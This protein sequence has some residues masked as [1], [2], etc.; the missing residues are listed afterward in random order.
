M[1]R[2]LRLEV[3]NFR[4]WREGTVP[5]DRQVTVVLGDNRRGKSSTLNAIEWC[6][7]GREI[8]KKA[9][10]IAERV[11]WE[12]ERR[13]SDAG[14]EVAL[15]IE[16]EGEQARIVRRRKA[17]AGAREE[18]EVAVEVGGARLEQ[19]QARAWMRA[20]RLPDWETW[21]RAC[22]QHQEVLRGRLTVAEDRSQVVASL[23][24]MDEYDRLQRVLKDQQPGKLIGEIDRELGELDKV[25][26]YRLRAP[27]EELY[28]SERKLEALGI[29]RARLSPG[30]AGEIARAAI[31][32]AGALAARLEIQARLPALEGDADEP[33]VRKW[34]DGWGSQVRKES[35]THERLASATKR[36]AK[37]AAEIEQLEPS[38]ARWREARK[39]LEAERAERGD[40]AAQR[41]SLAESERLV[42]HAESALRAEDRALAVLREALELLKLGPHGE[43]CP[44]CETHVPG[45]AGHIEARVRAGTGERAAK[46]AAERDRARARREVLEGSIRRLEKL[47]AE[48]K[49]AREA[50][51]GRRETLAALVSPGRL[52]GGADLLA[53][54]R[55]EEEV[56]AGEIASLET[57]ITGL[58]IELEEHRKDSERLRELFK[59]RAAAR[60]AQQRADL[61]VS[62]EWKGFQTAVDEA[63][64]F[65][66]DIDVLGSMAREAQEERSQA[67][68]AEVNRALGEYCALIAGREA[69][70]DPRVRVKRTPKG[71]TYEIEDAGGGRALSILNQAS[72]NAI[73]LSLLF[74]QAEE[75]A[76]E[77]LPEM[78]VLD[79]PGQSLDEDYAAG[80]ARAIER[81]ARHCAVIVGTTPGR[82][83][84]RLMSHVS[85][86]RRILRLAP[87]P[88]G[89]RLEDGV[90]IES[91]EER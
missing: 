52:E 54:A 37:L 13:G 31:E 77:G 67:R 39:R 58:E 16:I 73:S 83:A 25:V 63:A 50:F 6:L 86:P 56:L 22:C 78:L 85:H 24:G 35:R 20:K 72:L 5:L 64:A 80:L 21:R 9:S 15:S 81:V 62:P 34:A 88:V 53:A 75:R 87:P 40:D 29:E 41:H 3:R 18:D 19:D 27:S 49:E 59:W 61:T 28:E 84:E 48:E 57:V 55:A 4:G 2:P 42:E 36:R 23:L 90:R 11:D 76:R 91:Q 7:Y 51:E 46:L 38:E 66:A 44:V 69:C 12:I 17:G 30:L 1:M 79:D 8:E 45:L 43:R 65:A 74:A 32:R 89:E 10:G 60:W 47:G 33:A 70:L 26:L 68:E 82:L 14:V 71:I